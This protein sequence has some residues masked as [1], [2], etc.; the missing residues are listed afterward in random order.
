MNLGAFPHQ[1]AGPMVAL[2]ASADG[3]V[4]VGNVLITNNEADRAFFWTEDEDVWTD[5]AG[6][7]PLLNVLQDDQ[8]IDMT[9]NWP[10]SAAGVSSDGT[11][12]VG[13]GFTQPGFVVQAFRAVLVPRD[14]PKSIS[15]EA[16]AGRIGVST[17]P[18]PAR[19]AVTLAIAVPITGEMRIEV[20]DV[21]GRQVATVHDGPLAAGEHSLSLDAAPLAPGVYVIRAVAPTGMTVSRRLTVVR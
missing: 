14:P 16:A 13:Y 2:S 10:I 1:A 4:V 3:S 7:H 8:G 6:M 12:I 17:H 11:V 19:S 9:G 5:E 20:Y 18:N 21:M 15:H